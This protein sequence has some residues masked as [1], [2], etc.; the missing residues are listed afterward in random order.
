MSANMSEKSTLIK[1]EN[2][3]QKF[4]GRYR[5]QFELL[6]GSTL[7]QHRG[8]STFDYYTLGKQLEA[9]EQYKSLVEEDGNL[10]QLGRIPWVAL[11]VITVV[12]GTSILPLIATVQPKHALAA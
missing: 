4:F 8:L 1:I 6:E 3:A 12:Y 2:E 11:D 5:S 10:N 7:A 9:F